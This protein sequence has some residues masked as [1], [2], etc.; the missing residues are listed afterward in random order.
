MIKIFQKDAPI[1][2]KVSREVKASELSSEDFKDLIKKL[3]EALKQEK[4]GY[5]VAAPQ[6]G[7]SLRVFL[8]SGTLIRNTKKTDEPQDDRV[9]INPKIVKRSKETE[10]LEEGC[11]SVRWWYGMVERHKKVKIEALTED[12]KAFQEGAGGVLAQAFQHEIDHLDG[13]LF[14]DRAVDLKE[15]PPLEE[16]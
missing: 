11:L 10:M 9:Y 6:L 7:V 8:I 3:K 4:D 5:A 14:T 13:I 2:R 15:S 16:A 1:L 12:G